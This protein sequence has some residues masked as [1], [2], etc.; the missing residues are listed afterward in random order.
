[1]PEER[2]SKL[3]TS[4]INLN[5]KFS[6]FIAIESARKERDKQQ[7]EINKNILDHIKKYQEDDKA[8]IERARKWQSWLDDFIGKKVLPIAIGL[9]FIAMLSAAGYGIIGK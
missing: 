5:D 4:L 1:M 2:L 3:E 8:V 6:E 7:L 9:I